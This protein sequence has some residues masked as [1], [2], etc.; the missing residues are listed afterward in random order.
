MEIL[1]CVSTRVRPAIRNMPV[2]IRIC[3]ISAFVWGILAHGMAL[4]T[5]FA[6]ADEAYYLFSVGGTV[7]SG[8]WFL[9][10]LGTAVRWVFGSPNFSL[11]LW[12]GLVTLFFTGLCS[13]ALV[14]WLE[15]KQKCSWILASGLLAVFPIMS[16]LFLYNFTAPYYIFGLLL[17]FLGGGL[18]CHRRSAASFL[19]SVAFVCLGLSIYQAFLSLFL[20]L[21]LVFFLKELSE[22]DQCSFSALL[23]EILWYLGGCAAIAVAYLIAVKLSLLV[24]GEKLS[25][26]KDISTMGAANLGQYLRRIRLAVYLFFFPARSDR[27]AFLLPYRLLDCYYLIL[28]VVALFGGWQILR[29][30]RECPLKAVTAVL[31][32]ALFPLAVNFI[33]VV[34]E[35]EDIYN[36]M[37]FGQIAPF[38]LLLSFTDQMILPAR[39]LSLVLLLIFCLFCVRTDNAVYTR[40]EFIQTRSI[41]YFNTLVSI[42]KSTPGYTSS[43]PVAFVGDTSYAMDSTYHSI[44]G[45]GALSIAPLPYDA[46]PFSIGYSWRQFLTLWCGFTPPYEDGTAFA[47]FPEIQKMP[48][49]PDSGSVQLVN[50]VV[51]VKIGCEVSK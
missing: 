34:C 30:F 18:L 11:P 1:N 37:L 14:W 4:V 29:F 19:A 24:A 28:G 7:T 47:V 26:Y 48:N 3:L 10:L 42:I 49:Y 23:K 51:V 43:T 13:C 33:Y 38:L 16:G 35:Q 27:Y 20:S 46:S 6:M 5:K 25:D 36:L 15:L 8:R 41:S 31:V 45:F 2:Y 44:E 40:A 22:R 50:G 21:L 32:C 39:R 12:S 17:V 9:G